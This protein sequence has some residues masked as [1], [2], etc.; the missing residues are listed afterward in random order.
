MIQYIFSSLFFFMLVLFAYI[1][2]KYPFWN[3]QPVFHTYDYWRFFY[4][5]PFII[6]KYRPV[7]TKYCDFHQIETTNYIESSQTIKNKMVNLLQCYYIP[8]EKILHTITCDDLDIIFTGI[9]EPSYISLFY[10]KII[11]NNDGQHPNI[12]VNPEPSGCIASRA[13]KMF[14]KP[15]SYETSYTMNLI[16]FIDYLCVSRERD[17]KKL[18]RMLL[19]THEY[20]QRTNNPNVLISL[21]KKEVEL[22]EGIIPLVKYNTTTYDIPNIL[23]YKLPPGFQVI[24]IVSSNI[25]IITDYLYNIIHNNYDNNEHMFDICI[26]QDASYYLSQIKAGNMIIYCLQHREHIYGVYFFKNTH[27]EYEDIEGKV[28]MFSSSIKNVNNNELF[29]IGFLRSMYHLLKKN[30]HYKM[31]TIENI[32]HNS[33]ILTYW[34]LYNKRIFN[35]I[36]AYYL[37]NFIYPGSPLLSNRTL[38]LL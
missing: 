25:A 11:Q 7:K 9:N 10:D 15:T 31:L 23:F 35:N 38:L 33:D 27:T 32:G 28:L 30:K 37:Y 24:Q 14:Y 21:L 20:N 19:Q 18:N 29:Y 1:K 34:D 2:I 17:R 22:F 36:T 16:Y 12:L 3:N 13:Y 6:Y 4:S 5:I 8:S 26:I